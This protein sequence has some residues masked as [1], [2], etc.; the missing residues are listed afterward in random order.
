MICTRLIQIFWCGFDKCVVAQLRHEAKSM[1]KKEKIEMFHKSATYLSQVHA[2][3]KDA[4]TKVLQCVAVCCSVLQCVAV[5]GSVL[6]CV[7]VC[8]SVLQCVA[9]CCSVRVRCSVFQ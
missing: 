3:V 7:A 5:C 9:V 2:K 8:C 6:Q 1:I 4:L